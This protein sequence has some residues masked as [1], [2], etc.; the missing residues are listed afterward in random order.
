MKT[1]KE[2]EIFAKENYVPIARK[3]TVEFILDYIKKNNYKSFL[4][5][6][7]AIGYTSLYLCTNVEGLEIVTIEHDLNRVQQAKENFVDFNVEHLITMVIDDAVSFETNKMFDLIFVDAA[8]KRNWF[9]VE[10]FSKNLNPNGTIIVDNLHLDD[11]WVGANENKKKEYD[12]VNKEFR[13]TIISSTKYTHE[14][15]DDIGDGIVLLKKR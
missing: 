4:E 7:T 13:E 5:I 15:R 3:Q 11:F 2:I 14:F 1:L 10:K 6:G 9:F 8:K 12:L